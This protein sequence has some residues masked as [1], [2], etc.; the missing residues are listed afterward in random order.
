MEHSTM[1]EDEAQIILNQSPSR[2][3]YDIYV[4]KGIGP[5]RMNKVMCQPT[6]ARAIEWCERNGYKVVHKPYA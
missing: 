1:K 5:W 3:I 6:L 4:P 2:P